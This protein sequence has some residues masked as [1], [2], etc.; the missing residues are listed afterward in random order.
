MARHVGIGGGLQGSHNAT[1]VSL[2][3]TIRAGSRT[4]K[5]RR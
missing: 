4:G 2:P 3:W 5:A 1:E